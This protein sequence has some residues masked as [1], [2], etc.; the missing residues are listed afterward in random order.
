MAKSAGAKRSFTLSV[1]TI[2]CPFLVDI[3]ESLQ[4]PQTSFP[5]AFFCCIVVA[6]VLRL[7]LTCD[8]LLSF[9]SEVYITDD[10]GC[11]MTRCLP[12]LVDAL[13]CMAQEDSAIVPRDPDPSLALCEMPV[14]NAAPVGFPSTRKLFYKT[15]GLCFGLQL[16]ISAFLHL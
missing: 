16:V 10:E 8:I 6:P 2:S 3:V 15:C 12:E 7:P 4:L 5:F 13:I 14:S 9:L 1:S 11:C